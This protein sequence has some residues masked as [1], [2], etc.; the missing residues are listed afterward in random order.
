MVSEPKQ[1]PGLSV[2]GVGGGVNNAGTL[3]SLC[4]TSSLVNIMA[5]SLKGSA[6][7]VPPGR[8]LELRGHSMPETRDDTIALEFKK[9]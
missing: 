8:F 7:C 2:T 1:L 6:T 4:S 9:K 5:S 3:T